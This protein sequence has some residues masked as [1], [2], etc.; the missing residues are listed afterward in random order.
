MGRGAWLATL[1]GVARV[2][3][4]LAT[5]SP[6]SCIAAQP[7]CKGLGS[8]FKNRDRNSPIYLAGLL[9]GS[10]EKIEILRDKTSQYY[11]TSRPR[12]GFHL[13]MRGSILGSGT[14]SPMV[15]LRTHF[16]CLCRASWLHPLITHFIQPLLSSCQDPLPLRGLNQP[17]LLHRILKEMVS[18]L[19]WWEHCP[20]HWGR[21]AHLPVTV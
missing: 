11:E 16:P 21:A 17:H 5:N 14:I 15:F 7:S 13:G 9:S 19:W 1:H 10:N 8:S 2:G 18:L 3:H 4:D 12:H 6:P 20:G